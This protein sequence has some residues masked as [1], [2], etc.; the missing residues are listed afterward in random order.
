[1][2][3]LTDTQEQSAAYA[4]ATDSYDPSTLGWVPETL[5]LLERQRKRAALLVELIP[6]DEEFILDL[7]RSRVLMSTGWL[8]DAERARR[9]LEPR[10]EASSVTM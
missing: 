10:I 7:S 9:A 1:M 2:A 6:V 3:A 8:T 4:D 5:Q